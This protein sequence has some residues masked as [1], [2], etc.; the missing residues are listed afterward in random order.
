MIKS[1]FLD[2]EGVVTKNGHILHG[3]FF[4]LLSK[5]C[6]FE[7]LAR[8]YEVA[9]TGKLKFNEFMEGVPKEKMKE[10]LAMVLYQKGAKEA[11]KKLSKKYPL[12]LASNHIP[13]FF[14]KSIK[15]LG[16]KKF[17]KK[18]FVSHKMGCAK[19]S[20][21]FY[22]KI[23]KG[24]RAKAN[25]SIFVDDAKRNLI[26]AKEMGFVTVWANNSVKDYRN[27]FDYKPDYEITDLRELIKIVE[28]INKKK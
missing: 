20:K 15:I 9:K 10:Y 26:P 21:E 27:D 5:Y 2:F 18:I 23:L 19:P 3:G 24:A 22:E 8:R 11:I 17:F 12:Y 16:A 13:T 25:E 4:P 6:S 14:E 1:I 28:E 7:E